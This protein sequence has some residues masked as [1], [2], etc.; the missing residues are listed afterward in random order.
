MTMWVISLA[1]LAHVTFTADV[2]KNFCPDTCI[3][4]YD[5]GKIFMC[6]SENPGSALI[7]YGNANANDN[8]YYCLTW[9]AREAQVISNNPSP[10]PTLPP[11]PT[12]TESP[13][14]VEPSPSPSNA[15]TSCYPVGTYGGSV[16]PDG[17]YMIP[18]ALECGV[19]GEELYPGSSFTETALD[20]KPFGCFHDDGGAGGG[21][22]FYNGR[23][24]FIAPRPQDRPICVLASCSECACDDLTAQCLSCHYGMTVPQYCQGSPMTEGCPEPTDPPTTASPSALPTSPPT[25]SPSAL[26][27]SSPTT[28]FPT[29][30]PSD[31]PTRNPLTIDCC[32]DT[33]KAVCLACAIGGM[34][35]DVCTDASNV[36]GCCN[37][38]MDESTCRTHFFY[39]CLWNFLEDRCT[40]IDNDPRYM[41]NLAMRSNFVRNYA[42][43]CVY[44]PP[45]TKSPTPSPITPPSDAPTPAPTSA[46]VVSYCTDV[47]SHRQ[48]L[49]LAEA[50]RQCEEVLVGCMS[51][52]GSKTSWQTYVCQ[53]T[54]CAKLSEELCLEV[55][56][57]N[58]VQRCTK[59]FKAN[60]E[61]RR[62]KNA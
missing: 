43:V 4:W 47:T 19:A 44:T 34:L 50:I 59:M 27:T 10:N 48:T 35:S 40:F 29:L 5:G 28:P 26:P 41:L 17:S 22:V 57:E 12:P 56:D 61:Y 54:P 30:S 2:T 3:A 6:D 1:L 9:R 31:A 20:T 25:A 55:T 15:P 37:R 33:D 11:S 39:G 53:K 49:G 24:T 21:S 32:E 52:E 18:N 51:L 60:G 38:Y 23:V 16:C 58:G 45:P 62:C 36:K 46:A 7:S 8:G 14:T 13:T 42:G